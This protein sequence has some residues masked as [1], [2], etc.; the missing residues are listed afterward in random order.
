MASAAVFAHANASTTLPALTGLRLVGWWIFVPLP[1]VGCLLAAGLYAIGVRRLAQ[2]GRRWPAG[3]SV[4]FGVG[5]AVLAVATC[6]GIGRYDDTLFSVH[7]AQHMLLGMV[8]P[9]FLALGAPV[10]L[11][12]QASNRPTQRRLLGVL[13][14]RPFQ[15]LTNP[16]V[17]WALMGG[18]SFVLYFTPL[19]EAT[20]RHDWLHELVH[21]HFV[22]VG[23]LFFW[24]VV[25]LDP[26]R[27][28]LSHPARL[29]YVMLAVPFHVFL[30]LAVLSAHPP[31]A[32]SYYAALHRH[33]G[34]SLAA[35]Q[36][37]GG[38][39]LWAVGDLFGLIPGAVVVAQWLQADE[40]RQA[41]EDAALDAAQASG[42]G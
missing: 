12:L 6:S 3:R 1:A 14:S 39:I 32:A 26:Q 24:P 18:S 2:R 22:A 41:R 42:V 25:A 19:Y 10:T 21:L 34:P 5:V 23:V 31:I 37:I 9:F 15:T 7:M 40:R 35:D 30:G 11:A 36:R 20:L 33:W 27:H 38:G 17:G 16:L 29:L 4:C 8:G 13:H 28:P